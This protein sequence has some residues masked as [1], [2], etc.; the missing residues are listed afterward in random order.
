MMGMYDDNSLVVQ[1]YLVWPPSVR[2]GSVHVY[3]ARE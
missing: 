3:D 1:Q 2:V